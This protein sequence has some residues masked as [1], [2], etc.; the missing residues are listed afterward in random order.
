MITNHW[1]RY[2]ISTLFC[3]ALGVGLTGDIRRVRDILAFDAQ[4]P[5]T[6]LRRIY[7]EPCGCDQDADRFNAAVASLGSGGTL[8]LG[9]GTFIMRAT[10]EV[11]R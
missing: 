5:P 8:Y 10:P 11:N 2:F 6:N 9:P 7:L 4:V 1:Q 3:F